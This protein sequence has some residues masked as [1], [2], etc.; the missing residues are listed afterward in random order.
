MKKALRNLF[1]IFIPVIFLLGTVSCASNKLY[2]WGRYSDD[3]YDYSKNPS[4]ANKTQLITQME[5][6]ID[7]QSSGIRNVVPPGI[8][9]D[10]GYFLI[11]EGRTKEGIENLKKEMEL[12]PES[13]MFIQKIIDMFEEEEE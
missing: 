13:G 8:F 4:D 3:C 11:T 12:Y 10:Y 7:N 5:K 2:Y 6:M 9:A 1:F